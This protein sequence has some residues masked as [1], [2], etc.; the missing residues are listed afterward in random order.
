MA[1]TGPEDETLTVA[2]D[3]V[4]PAGGYYGAGG[5]GQETSLSHPLAGDRRQICA[6]DTLL[7]IQPPGTKFGV[8]GQLF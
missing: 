1:S 5:E 8:P 7:G 2:S 6:A 4:G 3:R